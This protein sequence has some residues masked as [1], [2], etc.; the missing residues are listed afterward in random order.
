[1]NNVI[2][3]TCHT[4][5]ADIAAAIACDEPYDTIVREMRD[6]IFTD[7]KIDEAAVL[8]IAT[9][10]VDAMIAQHGFDQTAAPL[11]STPRSE[12]NQE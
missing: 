4:G 8:T 7:P 12:Q 2:N 3:D 6:L 11:S 10:V 1:M 5:L 9:L